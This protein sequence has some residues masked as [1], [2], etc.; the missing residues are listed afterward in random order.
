MPGGSEGP[1]LST[2]KR[3]SDTRRCLEG[4]HVYR[5]GSEGVESKRL[6]CG[7]REC[8]V[9]RAQWN[10]G[11]FFRVMA[12][13]PDEGWQWVWYVV[14]TAPGVAGIRTGDEAVEWNRGS[15]LRLRHFMQ[16]VRRHAARQG[17]R[18]EYAA[19]PELQARGLVHYNVLLREA[20]V[21]DPGLFQRWAVAA[22]FGEVV[23]AEHARTRFGLVR[24][25][26]GYVIKA[27]DHFPPGFRAVRFSGGWA[28]W[29]E[30]PRAPSG[31]IA[32]PEDED[33][34]ILRRVKRAMT[35]RD[36]WASY[37][38]SCRMMFDARAK[39]RGWA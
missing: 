32:I 6:P 31:W 25:I 19:T 18:A 20:C 12:G 23:Y 17:E 34:R 37:E 24:Y 22:G 27:R 15:G 21:S 30:D 35:V 38:M 36:A 13:I 16:E 14:L 29:T 11:A 26:G 7:R 9:C 4:V 8:A 33:V 28:L 1:L 2:V 10:R 3:T 5:E 39:V